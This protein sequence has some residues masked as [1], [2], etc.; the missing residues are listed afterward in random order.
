[1]KIKQYI[2]T[3]NNN[4]ILHNCL[5]SIFNNLNDYELDILDVYVINNHSNFALEEKFKDK[6]NVI[7][8]YGRPDF[9]TGHLSRSWNQCIIHGFVDLNNPSVDIVATCQNDTI[10]KKNYVTNLIE[11]HKIYDFVN[12]GHGD[13]FISYTPNAIKKVGLWDE[14]FCNIGHQET[15]Y[16][17]RVARHLYEKSTYN[18]VGKHLPFHINPVNNN[19]I[20]IIQSGNER[21]DIN[22]IKSQE[23]HNHSLNILLKK[24]DLNAHP[25]YLKPTLDD[26][27]NYNQI[28]NNYF[29]YPYF[30]KNIDKN[31]LLIQKY[32]I[33][34]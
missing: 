20:E 1:M 11:L 7:H 34:D 30:E 6:V 32:I 4:K 10:F 23:Y 5:Q 26:V 2:V 9:S 14:R 22:H 29:Y 19:I 12:F 8:N 28:L 16:F 17:I 33:N 15:D 27:L 3:Y 25:V 18:D 21:H 24:W 31:S 13:N